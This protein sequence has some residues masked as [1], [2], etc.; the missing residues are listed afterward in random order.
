MYRLFVT[1]TLILSSDKEQKRTINIVARIID[2]F[3]FLRHTCRGCS[4]N[5]I[6]TGV[7][8]FER[9]VGGLQ[10]VLILSRNKEQKNGKINIVARI[11]DGFFFP[12]AH[13]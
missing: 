3:F 12:F 9:V 2:R 8:F 5:S 6:H 10:R 11:I 4:S 7:D 1:W 13:M